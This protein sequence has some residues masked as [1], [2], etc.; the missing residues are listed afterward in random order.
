M[1]EENVK[2]AMVSIFDP[3]LNAYREVPVSIAEQFVAQ[4]ED[5]NKQIEAVK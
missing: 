5:I 1:T 4:V 2:E 3:F